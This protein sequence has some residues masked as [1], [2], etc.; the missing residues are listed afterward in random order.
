MTTRE[1]EKKAT[2][3]CIAKHKNS[4]FPS[5]TPGLERGRLKGEGGLE[6]IIETTTS[7]SFLILHKSSFLFTSS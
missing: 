2:S 4:P 1:T 5:E 3:V 6:T 7:T